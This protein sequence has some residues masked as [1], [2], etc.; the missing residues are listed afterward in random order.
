MGAKSRRRRPR[1]KQQ[2]TSAPDPAVDDWG[3]ES[4]DDDE[5]DDLPPPPIAPPAD[6]GEEPPDTVKALGAPPVD[7]R[8]GQKWSYNLLLAQAADAANDAKISRAQQRKETR[9]I[10]AAAAKH[11]PDAARF[12]NA[13]AS[14]AAAEQLEGRKRARARAQ[15]EARPAAGGAKVIPIRNG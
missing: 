10:L 1:R 6:A 12:D 11:Y 7:A 15:L 5:V 8:G 4:E 2:T 14:R 3:S 13:E 9:V